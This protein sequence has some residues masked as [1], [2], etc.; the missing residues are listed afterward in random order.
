MTEK[1][2][3]SFT[4]IPEGVSRIAKIKDKPFSIY[5]KMIYSDFLAWRRSGVEI[6]HPSHKYFMLRYCFATSTIKRA[7]NDLVYFGLLTKVNRKG[8]SNSY[9]VHSISS[10][11]DVLYSSEYKVYLNQIEQESKSHSVPERPP[12]QD[13][14]ICLCGSFDCD[15][16][17]PE[18]L[19]F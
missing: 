7:I 13:K 17:S 6:I 15:G 2:N 5:A 1:V 12:E 9:K 16:T 19:P 18:C 11:T 10:C 14:E 8:T 3:D 4:A